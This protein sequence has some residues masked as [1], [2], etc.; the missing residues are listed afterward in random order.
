MWQ[1][2]VFD[3]P[4]W[5]PFAEQVRATRHDTSE[6]QS[7]LIERAVPAINIRLTA[8]ESTIGHQTTMM[9][10]GFQRMEAQVQSLSD[11]VKDWTDGNMTFMLT[12]SR[13]RYV[14]QP[15][16]SRPCPETPTPM[17]R[18][19]PPPFNPPSSSAPDATASTFLKMPH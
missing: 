11:I 14:T 3:H 2:A 13:N 5:A 18:P 1:H 10:A 7:L 17:A 6:P 12:P 8:M 4:L 9:M 19:A 16:A 15:S